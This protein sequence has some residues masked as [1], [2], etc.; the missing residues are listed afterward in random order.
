[1]PTSDSSKPDIGILVRCQNCSIL[2]RRITSMSNA[3]GTVPLDDVQLLCPACNSN[4]YE[5]ANQ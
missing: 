5:G 3:G 4:A 1:M 2:W